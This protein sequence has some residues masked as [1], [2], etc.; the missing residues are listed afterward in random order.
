M[1]KSFKE[2]EEIRLN[3]GIEMVLTLYVQKTTLTIS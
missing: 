2:I 1:S 3:F